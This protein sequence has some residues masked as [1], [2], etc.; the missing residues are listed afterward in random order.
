MAPVGAPIT[1]ADADIFHARLRPHGLKFR[2]SALAILVDLDRLD[3]PTRIPFFSIG[4]FNLV[5]FDARDH[6]PCDGTSLRAYIDRL[7]REASLPH[8]RR[9]T[10]VCFPR[11][12]G[13]VFNPIATYVCADDLGRTTSVVYEVRNT[14]GERHTYVMATRD[15]GEGGVEPHE[16]DKIFY[17]SPFMDMAMRYRF[18]LS[19]PRDGAFALKIIERDHDGVVLTALMRANAFE[20]SAW[21]LL[22]RVVATPLLGF[23]VLAAIHW[24]AL[25]LWLRGHRVRPRPQPPEPVSR[26]APGAF[27]LTS[28][29]SSPG[30]PNA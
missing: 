30:V 5:S 2:Y 26:D 28:K 19:P 3:E 20:A 8:P 22:K 21:S 12:L 10:L 11:I 14:F 29:T 9:V 25:R 1:F 7:H 23:K 17:V 13:F 27:T 18:R 24:Q 4:K 6:G 16:C 15:A